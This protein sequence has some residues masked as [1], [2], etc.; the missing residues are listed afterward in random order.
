G[1]VDRL[2]DGAGDERLHRAHH[3]DV[4]E[5]MDRARAARRLE[6]AIEDREIVRP[7]RRGV[8]DGLLLVDVLDDLLDLLRVVAESLQGARDR[9]VDDLQEPAADELLVLDERDVGL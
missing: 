3:P 2:R 4:A 6:G 5:R 1:Y 7:E 8:L 9:V